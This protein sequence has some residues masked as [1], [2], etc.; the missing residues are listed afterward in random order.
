MNDPIQTESNHTTKEEKQESDPQTKAKKTISELLADGGGDDCD[1]ETCKMRRLA[2][3]I[4][5]K[6]ATTEQT[7]EFLGYIITMKLERLMNKSQVQTMEKQLEHLVLQIFEE[8][9]IQLGPF[10]FKST[11]IK[12]DEPKA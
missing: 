1:C 7:G 5:E 10:K 12:K 2:L 3:P 11:R 4:L 8:K 6:H 9:E